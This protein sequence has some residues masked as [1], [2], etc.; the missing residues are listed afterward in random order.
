MSVA[1][2]ARLMGTRERNRLSTRIVIAGGETVSAA[3]RRDIETGFGVPFCNFYGAYEARLIAL[4]EPGSRDL[5]VNEC[6]VLVELLDGDRPVEQGE[7]GEVVITVLHSYAMPFIRYRLGDRAIRGVDG[8]A[9]GSAS[10]SLRAVE[11]RMLE[12]FYLSSGRRL[13]PYAFAD[14][15]ELEARWVRR[16]RITQEAPDS[17]HI[18]LAPARGVRPGQE[19]MDAIERLMVSVTDEP[20]RISVKLVDEIRPM[21]NGKHQQYIPLGA[22][23]AAAS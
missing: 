9:G 6:G 16:F 14:P 17:L 11:G 8:A 22:G 1:E 12:F 5:R 15:I 10:G 13:H 23:Q 4:Q 19:E 21:P 7:A 18:E 20:V 2:V 3:T